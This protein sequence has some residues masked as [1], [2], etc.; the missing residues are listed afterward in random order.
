MKKRT[1]K[2]KGLHYWALC[3]EHLEE[4]CRVQGSGLTELNPMMESHWKRR[5][6][7]TWKPRFIWGFIGFAG[8]K[9]QGNTLESL[10]LCT[11]DDTS[12]WA[13]QTFSGGDF[14]ASGLW[15]IR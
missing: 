14:F 1:C 15:H 3:K 9:P 11:V 2:W 10:I 13:S 4:G 5:L 8:G 12:H 6:N 7:M